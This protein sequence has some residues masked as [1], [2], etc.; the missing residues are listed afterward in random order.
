MSALALLKENGPVSFRPN[1]IELKGLSK[2]FGK[3]S[4]LED[5]SFRVRKKEI[6]AILG[7]SGSGKSTLP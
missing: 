7:S 2:H 5:I 3:L 1:I 4:V 6:L